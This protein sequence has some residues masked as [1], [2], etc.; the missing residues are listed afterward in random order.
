MGAVI[1]AKVVKGKK[2][3]YVWGAKGDH[4]WEKFYPGVQSRSELFEQLREELGLQA[5]TSRSSVIM[6]LRDKTWTGTEWVDDFTLRLREKR[7]EAGF[8]Q[9]QLAEK[10][11]LSPQAIAAL[12]QGK[13]G[14]TWDTVRRLAHALNVGVEA[15]KVDPPQGEAE[16]VMKVGHAE[17]ESE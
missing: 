9:V 15:F 14:P 4:K 3:W 2:L 5:T 8:T 1:H 10:A 16:N 17:Q 12:E 7:E 6:V 11:G 13:R